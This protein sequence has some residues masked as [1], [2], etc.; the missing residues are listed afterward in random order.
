MSPSQTMALRQQTH[1]SNG[2]HADRVAVGGLGRHID[3][4]ARQVVGT[5]LPAESVELLFAIVDGRSGDDQPVSRTGVISDEFWAAVE[6]T[7][8]SVGGKRGRR[9]H[10]HREA[11][12]WPFRRD[13]PRRD[14]PEDMVP[15]PV[16]DEDALLTQLAGRASY[17]RTGALR[18]DAKA[19]L[20]N[21]A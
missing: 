6:P 15:R 2:G 21:G 3:D 8:P 13:S 16:D 12:A 14:P 11:I 19:P 7:L 9:W 5:L 10:D 4:E 20:L 1:R 17:R 18:H